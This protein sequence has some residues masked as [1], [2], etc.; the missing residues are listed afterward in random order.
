MKLLLEARAD[1]SRSSA[2]LDRAQRG[3]HADCIELLRTAT[4]QA[5]EKALA[6]AAELLAGEALEEVKG[7]GGAK[8]KKKKDKALK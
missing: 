4:R 2:A 3:G 5:E 6:I 7:G 8:G 1:L